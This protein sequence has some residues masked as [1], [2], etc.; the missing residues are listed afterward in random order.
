M[1]RLDR[2][3]PVKD[4]GQLG[5]AIGREFP[6]PSCVHLLDREESRYLARA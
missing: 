1:R 4:I 2:L 3:A 5:A 6:I